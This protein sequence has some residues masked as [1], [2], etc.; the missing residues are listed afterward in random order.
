MSIVESK[1]SDDYLREMASYQ[2]EVSK[3]K[4]IDLVKAILNNEDL[5]LVNKLQDKYSVKLYLFDRAD[6]SVENSG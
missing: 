1:S 6:S 4:R 2:E 3:L 5:D